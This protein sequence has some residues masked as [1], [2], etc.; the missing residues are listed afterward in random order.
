M[1]TNYEPLGSYAILEFLGGTATRPVTAFRLRTV[2]HGVY[3]EMRVVTALVPDV[4]INAARE[5]FALAFE[6]LFGNPGVA[7]VSWGQEQTPSGQLSDQLTIYVSS[8]SGN[9]STELSFPYT[10]WQPQPWLAA[11][12]AEQQRLDQLE[13]G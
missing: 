11:A 7:D 12:A 9:S 13:A 4:D 3:A 2:P 5:D 1:A 10:L 8:T 6:N